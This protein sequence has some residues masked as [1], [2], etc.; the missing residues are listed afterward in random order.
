MEIV[1]IVA[2]VLVFATFYYKYTSSSF[3]KK[4]LRILENNFDRNDF[5]KVKSIDDLKEKLNISS[6]TMHSL[7]IPVIIKDA[8]HKI[9][10]FSKHKIENNRAFEDIDY[11]KIILNA[12]VEYAV[13]HQFSQSETIKLFL[14]A[15]NSEQV[16]KIYEEAKTQEEILEEFYGSLEELINHYK[17][18]L[19]A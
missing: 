4:A 3:P 11:E 2:I 14:I 5:S 19:N 18:S 12:V 17:K 8:S 16:N 6:D 1:V 15:L 9:K 7:A 13:Q 10:V